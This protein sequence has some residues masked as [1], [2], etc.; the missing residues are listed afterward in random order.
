[1]QATEARGSA[2]LERRQI[3]LVRNGSQRFDWNVLTGYLVRFT[4]TLH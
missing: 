1:M 3:I 2:V 4:Y